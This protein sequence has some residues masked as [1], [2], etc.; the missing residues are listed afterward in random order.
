V[1][2]SEPGTV[3]LK[4]ITLLRH[5]KSSWD[6]P[7]LSDFDRPL[8][9]RGRNDAPEMGRRLMAR[10][11]TPDLLIT[12][13]ARRAMSTARMAAREMGYPE[14]RII[15][16]SSLY[17]ASAGSIFS[18][19]NSLESLADHL[20]L[21]GHNPGFTDFAN[22]LSTARIDNM[23]TAALFCVDFDVDDW[24]A[25]RAADGAFVYFDFPKNKSDVLLPQ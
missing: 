1:A 20:M 18:V 21:V 4:R 15:P 6:E 2:E 23:P 12:S 19:V 17:H 9:P 11:Q 3:V 7:G 14:E 24:G 22:H 5:A 8:N 25:V 16:E 10:G 13:P